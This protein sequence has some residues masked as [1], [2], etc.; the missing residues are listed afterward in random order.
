MAKAQVKEM[1]RPII[2]IN[3]LLFDCSRLRAM[4]FALILMHNFMKFNR[5]FHQNI[6]INPFPADYSYLRAS[7]GFI[8]AARQ[9]CHKTVRMAIP[10]IIVHERMKTPIFSFIR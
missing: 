5:I 8:V 10:V 6:F 3:V 9:L 1:V 7:T 2:F 4:S